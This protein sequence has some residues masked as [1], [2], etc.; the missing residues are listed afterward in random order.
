MIAK[1]KSLEK[2]Q[3]LQYFK[4]YYLLR[5][6]AVILVICAIGSY[7]FEVQRGK[8]IILN[9]SFINLN[10]ESEGVGAIK[11][12]VKKNN[13]INKKKI[14]EVG[15]GGNIKDAMDMSNVYAMSSK[16][17]V[18]DPDILL[19]DKIGYEA[20]AL[21]KPFL[22]LEDVFK[23]DDYFKDII[24]KYGVRNKDIDGNVTYIDAI[25]ISNTNFAKNYISTNDESNVY[26]TIAAGSGNLEYAKM[27]LRYLE[28]S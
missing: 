8:Q 21:S 4:D 14:I 16:L 19:S 9:V 13:K 20:L 23:D 1:L 17:M 25:D 10:V 18:G 27:V 3:R 28:E 5:C 26:F 11:V 15:F 6:I 7:V 24:E 22:N 12:D 2:G